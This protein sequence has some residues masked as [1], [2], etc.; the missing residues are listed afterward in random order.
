MQFVP[1]AGFASSILSSK[2]HPTLVIGALQ[3]VELLLAKVP[4]EYKPVFRREGVFHE[5][6]SLASRSVTSSKSKDK[7]KNAD[8]DVS[9]APSPGDTGLPAGVPV[10]I[11]VISAIPGYK[12]LSS[13]SIEPDDA[14]TLRARVIKFKHLATSDSSGNDDVFAM[15]RRLVERITNTATSEKDLAAALEELATLFGH[16]HT[17]VSSFELLQSGV[18]DGLLQFFSEEEERTGELHLVRED[19][20]F[21]LVHSAPRPSSGAVLYC[22]YRQ[23]GERVWETDAVCSVREEASGESHKDG[24]VRGRERR[25]E[26]RWYVFVPT[27]PCFTRSEGGR[28]RL[29]EEFAIPPGPSIAAPSRCG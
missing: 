16:Q 23:E 9:E 14:I 2:D 11:S 4:A 20:L 3:L 27:I 17:S 22:L 13:L 8:K 29:E 1:V 10:A 12:K 21:L 6:E 24:I 5:I 25:A 28:C 19:G 18:I 15:L 7:D 26:R